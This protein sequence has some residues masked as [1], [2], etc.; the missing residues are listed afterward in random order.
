MPSSSVGPA[1]TIY[2]CFSIFKWV[3]ILLA[4]VTFGAS[5]LEAEWYRGRHEIESE[6]ALIDHMDHLLFLPNQSAGNW[7]LIVSLHGKGQEGD[8]DM[9]LLH[10]LPRIADSDPDV[11]ALAALGR[12]EGDPLTVW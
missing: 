2:G 9:L 5:S 1:D 3:S 7:P 10:E 11:L 4:L 8:D 6:H 12:G